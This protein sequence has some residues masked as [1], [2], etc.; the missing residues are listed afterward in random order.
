MPKKM[1][2]LLI[3]LFG[4]LLMAACKT[5]PEP[6]PTTEPA[7]IAP[8]NAPTSAPTGVPPTAAVVPTEAEPAGSGMTVAD[9]MAAEAAEV[10]ASFANIYASDIFPLSFGLPENWVVSEDESGVV[11]EAAEGMLQAMPDVDGTVMLILPRNDL[12]AEGVI[13]AL[14]QSIAAANVPSDIFIRR[15]SAVVY[16][17]HDAA[18]AW[19]ELQESETEGYYAFVKKGETGVFIFSAATGTAI[20]SNMPQLLAVIKSVILE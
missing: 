6:P 4:L 10:R 2:I 7:S 3:G 11:I 17:G 15:P 12:S 16:D 5:D 13:E 1:M 9:A 18:V 19:Y 14:R 8:T 20:S